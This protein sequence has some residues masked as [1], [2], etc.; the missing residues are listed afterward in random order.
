MSRRE[1]AGRHAL[2]LLAI[3]ASGCT[4]RA[5]TP[6]QSDAAMVDAALPPECTEGATECDVLALRTCTGGRWATTETCTAVCDAT[7]GCIDCSPEDGRTCV[8][9][10]VRA[11]TDRGTI[12]GI[13]ETCPAEAA[14]TGGY[15]GGCAA[16]TDLVYLVDA[17]SHLFAFD[18]R[19]LA[20][21]DRGAIACAS[22]GATGSPYSMAVDR[23]GHAWVLYDD[24]RLFL[25]DIADASCEATG[26]V[27]DQ[28]QMHT[29]GM[30]FSRGAAGAAE[31]L[32]V[33]GGPDLGTAE[34][35][36]RLAILDTRSLTLSPI[37][38]VTTLGPYYPELTG[39]AAG[40]LFGFFPSETY[41]ARV[42][43][44]RPESGRIGTTWD[45]VALDP[46][47][48]IAAWAFA[49]WGGAFYLSLSIADPIVGVAS[50]SELF[51]LDPD[52][53]EVTYLRRDFHT[54]VGAGVSTCAP[55]VF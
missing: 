47:E 43:V 30:G 6:P 9:G 18:P 33:A 20:L 26:F 1:S 42:S 54:F 48:R 21:T 37:G 25:V 50:G 35:D 7:L 5:V 17:G 15:C 28:Q 40:G 31:R 38:S 51:R 34:R 11:C 16:D 23:R 36:T 27:P 22:A 32:F 2:L 45:T 4:E 13:L 39:D 3:A 12:G 55:L 24:G 8:D 52:S 49:R 53:G 41:P 19:T 29:F 10:N 44:V 14:C 46:G